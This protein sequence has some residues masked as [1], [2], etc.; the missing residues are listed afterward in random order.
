MLARAAIRLGIGPHSSCVILYVLL[1]SA[2]T[3]IALV[4][5]VYTGLVCRRCLYNSTFISG[6][7]LHT[8]RFTASATFVFGRAKWFGINDF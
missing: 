4:L 3:C 1:F 7:V 2:V 6:A 8:Y 5:N